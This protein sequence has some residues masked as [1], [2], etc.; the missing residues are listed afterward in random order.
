MKN[1]ENKQIEEND[2]DIG[3]GRNE[4]ISFTA[5]FSL[6]EYSKKLDNE[7]FFN[8]EF[9]RNYIWD[10]KRKSRFIESLLYDFPIPNIFLYKRPN[11]EK[12]MIIDGYQRISTI[13][14]FFHNKFSL[15][16]V[17]EDFIGRTFEDLSNNDQEMLRN[18]QVSATIVRQIQPNNESILYSIFDRLN[19]GGQ[20]LNNMEVRR[21]INFGPLIK[22]LEE[23]NL[24]PNWR[25]I[26]GKSKPDTRFS[27]VELILRVLAF[28]DSWDG[29]NNKVAEYTNLKTFLNLY[30]SA[31]R[32]EY[33]ENF[34]KI[35]PQVTKYIVDELGKKPFTLYSRPNYVLLDSIM[36]SLLIRMKKVNYLTKNLAEK[37]NKL[38]GNEEFKSIYEAKQGTMSGKSVNNRIKLSLDYLL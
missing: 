18:K 22:M 17:N 3:I 37:V 23:V 28:S 29:S 26:L 20:N 33:K 6:S 38:K 9:Q 2:I 15:I 25:L 21:A 10:D 16:N 12:Y 1:K 24:D 5:S 7:I 36:T 11:E 34:K 8:P 27:D 13:N 19:T 14:S 35:F 4:I 32:N 30:C 31:H